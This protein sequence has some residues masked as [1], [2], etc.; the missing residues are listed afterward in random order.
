MP[1]FPFQIL[2]Q[3]SYCFYIE[4]GDRLGFTN[5]MSSSPVGYVFVSSGLNVISASITGDNYPHI[6]DTVAFD[7]LELPYEFAISAIVDIGKKSFISRWIHWMNYGKVYTWFSIISQ[8]ELAQVVENL[9]LWR[10]RPSYPTKTTPWSP[11]LR[12]RRKTS[13]LRNRMVDAWWPADD[14]FKCISSQYN[15]HICFQNSQKKSQKFVP[16]GQV[17]KSLIQVMA[18]CRT[19]DKPLPEMITLHSFACHRARMSWIPPNCAAFKGSRFITVTMVCLCGFFHDP[20]VNWDQ[21]MDR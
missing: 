2:L 13:F 15:L 5:E 12:W 10:R 11:M 7:T 20:M 1:V 9:P 4:P 19:G 8:Y 16:W 18:L 17:N 6:N 14:I 3:T 21:S